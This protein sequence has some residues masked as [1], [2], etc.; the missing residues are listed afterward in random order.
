[1]TEADPVVRS[2]SV[3]ALRLFDIAYAIDLKKAEAL[4]AG[5]MASTAGRHRLSATPPKAVAFGEPPLVLGLPPVTL[6][7]PEGPMTAGVTA[8]LH[9]FGVATLALTIPA[10]DLPWGAFVARVNQ[11]AG[12]VA[13]FADL[14]G[15]LRDALGEALDRPAA[16]PIEEDY[17][18]AVVNRLDRPLSAEALQAR[19]DLIPL[20]TG[21]HRPL[22]AGARADLLR[23]RYSYHLD[24]LV[25]LTWDRAFLLEPRCETDVQDVLEVANAQLLEMRVY[26]ELLDAELPRIYDTVEAARRA[27]SFLSARRYARLARRLHGLVAEVTELTERVDNALQVTEDVYLARVYAAA[28][29]LFRVPVVSAAVDRKLAAVR[30]TYQALYEEASASRAELLEAA[31]LVLIAIEILLSLLRR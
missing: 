20:L 1:M 19:V 13:P 9:D 3:V 14:L 17:L 22:S 29:A 21:E 10:T 27:G 16:A 12:A 4:W 6:D 24:D 5:R 8:R 7:F 18:L 15:T 25:V 28:M 23:H 31:I 2:G 11:L 30:E 26:D